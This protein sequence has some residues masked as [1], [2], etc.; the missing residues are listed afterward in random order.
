MEVEELRKEEIERLQARTPTALELARQGGRT[1]PMGVPTSVYALSPYPIA[2]PWA[3]GSRVRDWDG[4]EY[5]DY[6]LGFGVSVWGHADPRIT[7]AIRARA[8]AGAHTGALSEEAV[9][10][11]DLLTERF[12]GDWIRFANSGTEATMD[13]LRLAR[14]HTGRTRVAKI[15]GAYHG[16]HDV[17]L[18]NANYPLDEPGPRPWG[19]GLSPRL[20]QEVEVLQFNDLQGASEAL[21]QEDL[22]ALII[23]PVLFN[24]GAIWPEDGYLEGLRQLCTEHGTVLIFDET[25]TGHTV[26][27]GGAEELFG[28]RPDVKTAGKG[29][30]GGLPCGAI[31]GMDPWGYE[32]LE[33]G[34]APHLG[35]FSGNP[36][37]AAAGVAALEILDRDAYRRLEDHGQELRTGW[38]S[39]IDEFKLPAYPI[40]AGAKS[41]LVWADP[42]EGRLRDYWDYRRRFDGQMA[43]LVWYW[44]V[45][46]GVWLA[47]GQD[48][49]T[50]HSIVHGPDEARLFE[51]NL[52]QLAG[53][54]RA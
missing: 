7:E 37:V 53:V 26:A 48:E 20:L 22:A 5:V 40:G 11:A 31:I 36:I 12:R 50:T 2:L 43:S 32:L 39:V 8:A 46:R 23:E 21:G 35:T 41:C 16:S 3:N 33:K 25:K 6:S 28:V 13:A 29:I 34:R 14:A 42:E 18:I 45:N 4:N 30:G 52:R 9:L 10:W 15:D 47:Q 54:L 51:D 17:A 24:V 49:Q 19:A 44:M 1:M 38:Q 27:W